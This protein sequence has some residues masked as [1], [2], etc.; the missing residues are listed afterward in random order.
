MNRVSPH[1]HRTEFSCKCKCGL[2]AVDTSGLE[3]LE[4]I[5]THFDAPVKITSGNR[6][7]AHNAN[8]GGS[9]NSQHMNCLAYDFKVK[10]HHPQ[11]VYDYIND[12]IDPPGLGIYNTW[13]HMDFRTGSYARWDKRD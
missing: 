5:R 8:V 4:K 9:E 2:D 3:A 7:L 11:D 1:F 6:C 13:V 10:G 12:V